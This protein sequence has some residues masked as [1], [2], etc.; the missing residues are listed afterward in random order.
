MRVDTAI[1]YIQSAMDSYTEAPLM[2][3]AW[4]TLKTHCTQP[5]SVQQLKPKM[6]LLVEVQ[7]AL[8][9]MDELVVD[10]KYYKCGVLDCYKYI[11]RHIGH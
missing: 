3:D 6:P 11:S 5:A 10:D 2:M 1:R 7:H 9:D 8:F 4:Q